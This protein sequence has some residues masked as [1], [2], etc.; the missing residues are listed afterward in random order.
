[1]AEIIA[2]KMEDSYNLLKIYDPTCGGGNLFGWKTGSMKNSPELT[3]TFGQDWNDALYALAKIESR[4]RQ[5]SKIEH[6]NTLTE[7]KFYNDSFDVVIA[8]P[9]YGVTGRAMKKAS[10]PIKPNGLNISLLFLMAEA[11]V[12]AA[13]GLQNE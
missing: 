5:D 10:K 13:P 4:F 3:E 2:D 12:Y 8:N 9:P 11:V 7:D 6:G 1:M